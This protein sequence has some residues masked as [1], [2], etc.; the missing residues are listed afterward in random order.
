MFVCLLCMQVSTALAQ[1]IKDLE[2]SITK[3]KKEQIK[4]LKKEQGYSS[5][6]VIVPNSSYWY[7]LVTKKD[8][9]YGKITG[10]LTPDE[11]ILIPVKYNQI[12]YFS[13][14]PEGKSPTARYDALFNKTYPPYMLYH[15][16]SPAVFVASS[17]G[18]IDFY[19]TDGNLLNQCEGT[20]YKYLPGYFVID[21]K[22]IDKFP[23]LESYLEI[24]NAKYL[25]QQNGS[26]MISNIESFEF[27]KDKDFCPYSQIQVDGVKRKGVYFIK[28]PEGN[29]PPVFHDINWNTNEVE[30]VGW[31]VMRTASSLWEKYD[32][33]KNYTICYKD[34]GEEYFDKKMYDEVISY[35]KEQKSTEPYA[36]YLTALSLF[37][38][39]DKQ[40][41][42]IPSFYRDVV[43]TKVYFTLSSVRKE[44]EQE[45]FDL[46]LAKSM[47]QTCCTLLNAYLEEDSAYTEKAQN[48]LKVANNRIIKTIIT[49]IIK[50]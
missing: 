16:E 1:R 31:E 29:I 43:D 13:A 42:R 8:P 44:Y 19:A 45:T 20:S 6:K 38:L 24:E 37:E 35:Y 46:E 30:K 23:F 40:I 47:L 4:A 10:V 14:L 2:K 7:Y 26:I 18:H 11:R 15:K 9:T 39:A 32:P 5:V 22:R 50:Q 3:E 41:D 49:E 28:N 17:S 48:K 25:L 36:K 27:R 34:K 21:A 33:L 12:D